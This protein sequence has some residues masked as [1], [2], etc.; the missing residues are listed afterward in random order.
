[1]ETGLFEI[2]ADHLTE[3]K[4]T[5]HVHPDSP[6]I[7]YTTFGQPKTVNFDND[8]VIAGEKETPQRR[9]TASTSLT[10]DRT[11]ERVPFAAGQ[12]AQLRARSPQPI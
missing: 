6:R 11:V 3:L 7:A 10:G 2:Q 8:S 5:R 1:M 4:K 9:V 12:L